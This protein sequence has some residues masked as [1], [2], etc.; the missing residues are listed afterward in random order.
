MHTRAVIAFLLICISAVAAQ[1]TPVLRA[2]TDAVVVPVT[3]TD[4]FGRFVHGLSADQ[5]E[6]TEGATRRDIVQFSAGREPVS[7]GIL[8]DISGS[9]TETPSARAD[10]DARWTDTRRALELLVSRLQSADEVS[11]AVFNDR[12][13]AASWTRDHVGLLR[14][15]DALR[16]GGGSVLLDAVPSVLPTFEL[17]RYQ[18]K[19]L[20]LIT[21]GNDVPR[22]RVEPSYYNSDNG[23]PG[24]DALTIIGESPET[25]RQRRIF[26]TKSAVRRSDVTLYALGMGTRKGASVDKVLLESLTIES[27][28]Y[29]EVLRNVAEIPAAVA[30]LWDDL[31]SQYLLA[32]IPGKADGKYHSIKV[33]TNDRRL[34]VRARGGYVAL[35]ASTK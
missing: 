27:G 32:F 8:L 2:E 1:E 15:F 28:G 31:Q 33:T 20:L 21:D 35:P 17:A 26:T 5:F 13:T 12:I 22:P 19:V 10:S 34:R 24:H 23:P 29:L 7:L 6:I 9:M 3:V 16:P 14:E 25:L 11:F 18:R 30:R 4:L